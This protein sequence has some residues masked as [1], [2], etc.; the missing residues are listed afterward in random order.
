MCFPRPDKVNQVNWN[1][2]ILK[3][4]IKA[5]SIILFNFPP[6]KLVLAAPYH[7]LFCHNKQC[8]QRTSKHTAW[9]WTKPW[10]KSEMKIWKIEI[11]RKNVLICF[12]FHWQYAMEKQEMSGESLV[13]LCVVIVFCFFVELLILPRWIQVSFICSFSAVIGAFI[14]S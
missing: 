4:I 12:S 10:L 14:I 2:C 9:N 1:G 7:F 13:C 8:W 5:I 6:V 3:A 11:A